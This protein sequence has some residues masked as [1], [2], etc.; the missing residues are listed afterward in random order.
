MYLVLNNLSQLNLANLVEEAIEEMQVRAESKSH[1]LFLSN[2]SNTI[3]DLPLLVSA[4]SDKLKQILIN[5]IDNAIKYTPEGGTIDVSIRRSGKEAIIS[6]RDT[7]VG[8]PKN[9][10]SRIFEKFQRLEGSYVKD[11]EG[12][13]LG[14]YIVKELTKAHGGRIWVD[15]KVNEGS[16]FSF[17]LPLYRNYYPSS[18]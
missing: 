2:V 16:I 10:L 3:L 5:L 7:G 8:I 12:T 13:G 9:L 15:S 6:I 14:L 4:D 1:T 18:G 17:S 11:S